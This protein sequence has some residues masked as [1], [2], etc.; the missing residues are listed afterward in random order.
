MDIQTSKKRFGSECGWKSQISECHSKPWEKRAKDQLWGAPIFGGHRG[1]ATYKGNNGVSKELEGNPV[2]EHHE[3]QMKNLF[4][5][6]YSVI[7]CKL[8]VFEC[9][10]SFIFIILVKGYQY[11]FCKSTFLNLF[12][13]FSFFLQALILKF[14][15]SS[16]LCYWFVYSM[17]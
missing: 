15:L 6:K 4:R 10:S 7:N 5:K 8:C 17:H 9:F 2:S 14:I 3:R 13:L 1:Q 11:F 12:P 16:S